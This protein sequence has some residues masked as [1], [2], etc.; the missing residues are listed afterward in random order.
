MGK[1]LSRLRGTW[2]DLELLGNR[3]SP[4][5]CSAT[6]SSH[7]PVMSSSRSFRFAAAAAFLT[8]LLYGVMAGL[9]RSW[10]SPRLALFFAVVFPAATSLWIALETQS[11]PLCFVVVVLSTT[12]CA[13]WIHAGWAI[14][15]L[16]GSVLC[17][18]LGAVSRELPQR[19]TLS[20]FLYTALCIMTGGMMRVKEEMI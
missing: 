8:P 20:L 19:Q 7:S 15:T 11:H 17:A 18:A 13:W 6:S 5:F 9:A 3:V 4:V 10:G 14:L 16:L 1:K 2:S 12:A